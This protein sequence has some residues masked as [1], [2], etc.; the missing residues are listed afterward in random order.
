MASIC[1]TTESHLNY[2]INIDFTSKT[3]GGAIATSVVETANLLDA[4]LI[5]AATMSGTS[6]IRVSNLRPKCLVLATCTSSEVARSLALNW[7]VYPLV[8]NVYK[9]TDEIIADAKER[10]NSFMDLNKD[11]LILITGGFP[12]NAKEKTTNFMKIEK[13]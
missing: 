7:A 10:A 12:N 9:T 5:V 2:E 13:I 11:D 1:E 8:T 3:I 4:K 6:A